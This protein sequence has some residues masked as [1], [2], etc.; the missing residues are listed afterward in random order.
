M[1]VVNKKIKSW[2]A[3]NNSDGKSQHMTCNNTSIV[4]LER[5]D[6]MN[7]ADQHGNASVREQFTD[8]SGA[9]IN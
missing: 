9:I 4:Q 8:F 5:G 1:L 2:Q 3:C 7:I 6:V